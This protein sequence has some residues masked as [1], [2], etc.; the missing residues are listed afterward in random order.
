MKLST[1]YYVLSLSEDTSR[2]YEAFRESLIDIDNTLFPVRALK[3]PFESEM[4]STHRQTL[5]GVLDENFGEYYDREPL[6]M[7]LAGSAR[8]R[9]EFTSMTRHARVIIGNT[10]SDHSDTSAS[11]LG[12]ITWDIV[13]HVMARAGGKIEHQLDAAERANNLRVGIDAVTK[14]VESGEGATLLVEESYQV[15][16]EYEALLL[17]EDNVVDVVI[18]KILAL[19]G[20]VLFVAEGSLS[21]V[22]R[23]A[24]IL[25]G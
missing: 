7:I 10:R 24:L 11:D 4:T 15:R 23:I 17:D 18:E 22:D 25:E 14:A 8:N 6:A 20:N 5:L 2:L 12:H 13:K 19:G 16:A 1:H 9:E 3:V 21:S